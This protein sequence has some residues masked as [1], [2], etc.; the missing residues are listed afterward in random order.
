MNHDNVSKPIY[1]SASQIKKWRECKRKWAYKYVDKRTEPVSPKAAFGTD[2]HS[3]LEH[4]ST[5][6]TTPPKTPQGEAAKALIG[7]APTPHTAIKL[8][9]GAAL[10]FDVNAP[11]DANLCEPKFELTLPELPGVVLIGFIDVLRPPDAAPMPTVQDYKSTGSLR[12]ALKDSTIRTHA[13]CPADPVAA[14]AWLEKQN[15]LCVDPQALL[16][17]KT[18]I[19]QYKLP[20][21]A[22]VRLWWPYVEVSNPRT[23]DRRVTGKRLVA[24]VLRFAPGAVESLAWEKL[25][26]DVKAIAEAKRTLEQAAD[27]PPDVGGCDMFGGCPHLDVCPI[28]SLDRIASAIGAAGNR[29]P[30]PE[31][32]KLLTLSPGIGTTALGHNPGSPM[33]STLD[34]LAALRNKSA[35]AAAAAPVPAPEV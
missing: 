12:Y 20:P 25:I 27:A 24:D 7:F 9:A 34:R 26:A 15:A 21:D 33:S 1:I 5:K 6:G 31:P 23:G 30:K 16:Y 32:A 35:A 29:T 19:A 17:A 11:V 2:V 10:P 22:K 13:D 3:H 14:L 28:S 4:W 8:P 18:A